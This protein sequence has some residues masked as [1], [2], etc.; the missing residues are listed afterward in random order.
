M[1][2]VFPKEELNSYGNFRTY[3]GSMREVAF[4]LEGLEPAT[5]P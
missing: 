4:Y 3:D 1:S 2:K 5:F